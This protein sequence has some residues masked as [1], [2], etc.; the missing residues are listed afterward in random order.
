MNDLGKSIQKMKRTSNRT[1]TRQTPV[2]GVKTMGEFDEKPKV[3]E[4]YGK[5]EENLRLG[6]K[7]KKAIF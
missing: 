2:C 7:S 1:V 6:N 3:Q 5:E 4:Y